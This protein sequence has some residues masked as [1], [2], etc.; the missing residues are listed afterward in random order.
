[1]DKTMK[2]WDTSSGSCRCVCAHPDSVVALKWH[3]SLPVVVTACLDKV[4]RVWDARSGVCVSELTGH[5]D[6]VT[7]L[8]FRQQPVMRGAESVAGE[9]IVSVSDDGT[10]KVFLLDLQALLV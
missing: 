1:M 4:V 5:R 9:V 7:N 6:I 10:A 2:I 3:A 8:D